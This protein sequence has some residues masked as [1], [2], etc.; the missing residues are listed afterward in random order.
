MTRPFIQNLNQIHKKIWDKSED[1]EINPDEIK[2]TIKKEAGYTVVNKYWEE[3]HNFDRI[4]QIPETQRW[5]VKKPEE[6]GIKKS[7]GEKK[8]K[9]LMLPEEVVNASEQY[10]V[11]FSAVMTE[12]LIDEISNTEQFIK[13]YLGESFNEKEAK[14]IFEM[15]KKELYD[16]KGGKKQ[17]ARRGRR[18]KNIYKNLFDE[19][20]I[21]KEERTHIEKLRKE[22]F[23]L[24]EM[25]GV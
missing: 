21:T 10:G 24:Q 19:E 5:I 1:G 7:T 3:L 2:K 12:A 11:N 4:E 6:A 17:M 18:R 14:F 23:E 13:D 9:Q 22:A 20:K 25:L 16:K 15:L 8:L